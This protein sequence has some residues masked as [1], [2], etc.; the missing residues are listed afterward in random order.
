MWLWPV[1]GKKRSVPF[2]TAGGALTATELLL[3]CTRNHE[4]YK[5]ENAR[6]IDIVARAVTGQNPLHSNKPKLITLSQ[7]SKQKISQIPL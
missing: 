3:D 1:A 2:L 7:L 6:A 4:C 5:L